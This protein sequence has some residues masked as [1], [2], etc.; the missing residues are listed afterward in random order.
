MFGLGSKEKRKIV[1]AIM[2]EQMKQILEQN[3]Q[4]IKLLAE[5]L[6]SP[7]SSSSSNATANQQRTE[8]IIESLSSNVTEFS[9]DPD[10]GSTFEIWYRR[11]EDLFL[12]DGSKLDDA[13]RVRLLLRKLNTSAHERYVNC[14]LPKHPRE[15]QFDETVTKLKKT[16]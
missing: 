16:F 8:Q 7:A 9:Y 13:A 12:L 2:D 6:L 1:A 15:F 10:G 14:I 11:Y 5:K 4:L 3:Q